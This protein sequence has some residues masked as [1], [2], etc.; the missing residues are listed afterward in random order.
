[1]TEKEDRHN[2]LAALLHTQRALEA[3]I[4]TID[5]NLDRHPPRQIRLQLIARRNRLVAELDSAR[6][7]INDIVA[8]RGAITPPDDTMVREL[9]ELADRVEDEANKTQQAEAAL[10]LVDNVLDTA[11][12]VRKMG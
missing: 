4:D 3:A 6:A 10:K 7:K 8:R 1:M 12:K 9:G 11:R 5:E 2:Q